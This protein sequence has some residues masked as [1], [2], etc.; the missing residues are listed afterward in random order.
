MALLTR[1]PTIIELFNRLSVI[2]YLLMDFH[3][4]WDE[5]RR[6]L[7]ERAEIKDKIQKLGYEP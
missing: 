4:S 7:Q 6:L 2:D 5:T 3:I 1:E